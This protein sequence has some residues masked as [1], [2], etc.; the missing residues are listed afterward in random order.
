MRTRGTTLE[1]AGLRY[2]R[3]TAASPPS[4][5]VL[6]CHGYGAPGTDLVP[7]S[8]E[9]IRTSPEIAAQV[10]FLF[11]EAPLTLGG[12]PGFEQRAW[13]PIDVLALEA[14]LQ[15]G[16]GLDRRLDCPEE[17]VGLRSRL[18]TIL[19]TERA[20]AGSAAS[21]PLPMSRVVV[22]GFSQGAMLSTDFAL[23]APDPPRALCAFSGTLL[24]E[25]AWREAAGRR[26]GGPG[27]GAGGLRVLQSHGRQ[28]PLLAFA[29]AEA[30][31]DLLVAGGAAVTFVPFVGQHEIPGPVLLAFRDLLVALLAES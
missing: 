23:H 2:H 3:I 18:Q 26:L 12:F 11:P 4:L 14:A 24:C 25:A 28:D 22:G 1:A 27:G 20:T 13:W 16:R 5:V 21:G 31:R 17:L 15:R 9:L 10:A 6:L 19:D 30:L 29:A 7:L 8:E